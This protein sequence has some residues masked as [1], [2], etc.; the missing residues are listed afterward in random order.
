MNRKLKAT[1]ITAAGC[2]GIA[3]LT[4]Y[5]VWFMAHPIIGI[6]TLGALIVAWFWTIVYI[7]LD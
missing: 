3:L 2:G 6:A 1:L 5:I 4:L 7:S